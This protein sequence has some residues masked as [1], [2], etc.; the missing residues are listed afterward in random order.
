MLCVVL[1]KVK[2][3]LVLNYHTMKMCG[4]QRYNCAHILNCVTGWRWPASC[5]GYFNPLGRGCVG[6][7]PSLGVIVKRNFI[8]PGANFTSGVQSMVNILVSYSNSFSVFLFFA[9]LLQD[10][11]DNYGSRDY[12]YLGGCLEEGKTIIP[13]MK[14]V[15][16]SEMLLIIYQTSWCN[17]PEDGHHQL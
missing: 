4:E 13:M 15:S 5:F 17:I 8:V 12:R 11:S 3:N 6:P 7:T 16:S 1:Y 10:N 2:V 9:F 14:A